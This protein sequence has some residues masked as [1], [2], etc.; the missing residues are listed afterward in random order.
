MRTFI[1][2]PLPRN[3][4]T[5]SGKFWN[6]FELNFVE[7]LCIP[8]CWAPLH[9]HDLAGT[10]SG[11]ASIFSTWSRHRGLKISWDS[12]FVRFPDLYQV[13]QIPK[14]CII[15]K[16]NRECTHSKIQLTYL[17]QVELRLL[18]SVT[19]YFIVSRG[20]K[21]KPYCFT[22][23]FFKFNNSRKFLETGRE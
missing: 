11:C 14:G 13:L 7:L 23:L 6:H 16:K 17:I 2:E 22:G 5:T 9:I 20:K 12:V 3:Y 1:P 19:S 8:Y 18:K 4:G 15:Q 21:N 10:H